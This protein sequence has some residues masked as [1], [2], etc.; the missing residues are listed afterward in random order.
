MTA[1][2]QEDTQGR[3]KN[4]KSIKD[5]ELLISNNEKGDGAKRDDAQD[6]DGTV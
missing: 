4:G 1:T 5:I 3:D 6:L 2:L